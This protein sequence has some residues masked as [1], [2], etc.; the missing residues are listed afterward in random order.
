[1][2]NATPSGN[3]L[4]VELLL[5]LSSLFGEAQFR[6]IA[7]RTL[8]QEAETMARFPSAFGR[9]LSTL[10]LATSPP[11]E[12]VLLAEEEAQDLKELLTVAHR[13]YDPSRMVVGGVQRTLPPLPLLEGRE[14]RDGM[15]TAYVCRDFTCSAPLH[16]PDALGQELVGSTRRAGGHDGLE[17][18]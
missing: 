5:R 8:V 17:E 6:R 1:M 15:A 7:I 9:L 14:V 18:R 13:A 2:D 4:A 11:V 10:S 16:G 3:S 12:I